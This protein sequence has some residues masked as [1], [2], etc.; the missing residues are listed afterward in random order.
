MGGGGGSYIVFCHVILNCIVYIINTQYFC[1]GFNNL[2]RKFSSFEFSADVGPPSSSTR[3]KK[4]FW[5]FLYW[6]LC[7]PC[8]HINSG[9]S[10]LWFLGP[11]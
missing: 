4:K 7:L 10:E 3:E 6:C 1:S 5:G 2:K 9:E 8:L 11:E